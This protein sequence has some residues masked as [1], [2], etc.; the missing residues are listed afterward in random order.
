[1][2]EQDSKPN[3]SILS[4]PLEENADPPKIYAVTNLR[5][6]VKPDLDEELTT[7]TGAPATCGTEV[8][9][10]CVPVETCVCNTV[11][12]HVGGQSGGC[13]CVG[14]CCVGDSCHTIY[15]YPY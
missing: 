14:N 7:P 2:S 10:T 1:M 8:V 15:H 4:V 9:C 11:T 12:Y 3:D 13:S 6:Y 5:A